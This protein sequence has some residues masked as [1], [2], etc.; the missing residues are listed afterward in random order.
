MKVLT[1]MEPTIQQ[2]QTDLGVHLDEIRATGRNRDE[3]APVWKHVTRP[4]ERCTSIA[5]VTWVR[6]PYKPEFFQAL[7]SQ[8]LKLL[9]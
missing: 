8:L 4:E 5:E 2:M 7:V 6:I 1:W 3:L 9:T